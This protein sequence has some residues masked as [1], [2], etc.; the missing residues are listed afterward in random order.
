MF[1]YARS[2]LSH[3]R[4]IPL[5]LFV[6]VLLTSCAGDSSFV[7]P[8][9]EGVEILQQ[10]TSE[11]TAPNQE[12]EINSSKPPPEDIKFGKISVNQG[13]S[14]SSVSSILQDNAGLL[15]FG[16]D[17]GL[18]KYDGY[19]FTVYKHDPEN[20]NTVSSNVIQTIYEDSKG[21]LWIGTINGLDQYDRAKDIWHHFPLDQVQVI[22]ED[23]KGVLWV[24]SLAGLFRFEEGENPG[25]V[26][27]LS[28]STFALCEDSAGE[29]WVATNSGLLKLGRDREIS[30]LYQHQPQED[31][32]LA[33]NAVRDIV[34]DSD[35]KL[36]IG[37][38]G[39][40]DKFDSAGEKFTHFMHDEID[41]F[42][43]SSDVIRKIFQDISGVLWVGTDSGLN[44]FDADIQGF[45]RYNFNAD[46]P[47]SLSSDQVRTI[48][49]D[50]GGII[51]IGTDAAGLNT[52]DTTQKNFIHQK[53]EGTNRDRLSNNLVFSLFEDYSE[54]LWI[55]TGGGGINRYDRSLDVYTHYH[56]DAKNP[57]SLS[58]DYVTSILVDMEGALWAGTKNGGLN[59]LD[60]YSGRFTHY[61]H[62]PEDPTSIAHDSVWVLMKDSLGV[63]W[64]GTQGGGLDSFDRLR[65]TFIH[66]EE[67][68]SNFVNTIYEDRD[69][70][71][72]VGTTAG[73]LNLYN[74]QDGEFTQYLHDPF[75]PDSISS[76]YVLSIYQDQEGILWIG[77]AGGGLNKFDPV[78]GM[79]QHF[80]EQDGLPNDVVYGILEDENGMLWLSTNGGLSKFD[81]K[82]G[83]FRNFDVR[84]GLQSNEF[85]QNAYFKNS[86]GEMFFGGVNGY[87]SFFPEEIYDDG[88]ISPVVLT[89]LTQSGGDVFSEKSPELIKEATFRW[90]NNFFEFEFASLSYSQ[91]EKNQHAYMLEGFR[92]EEWNYIGTK[93]FGRYT[94]LP[95]G[96]YVLRIKGSNK[97]GVWNQIGNS[98]YISVI[99]PIWMTWWFQVTAVLLIV[100]GVFA[101]YWLRIRN[102]QLRTV[103]LEDQVFNRTKE[104]ATLNSIATVVSSSLDLKKILN[105]ALVETLEL[106]QIEAG[107]VYLLRD[108]DEVLSIV[109]YQGLSESFISEIDNLNVGEGFSGRVVQS[110]EVLVIPDISHDSRLTRSI[111]KDSGYHTLI[112]IPLMSR[113]KSLGTLFLLTRDQRS[114]GNKD[115]DLLTAI[116]TQIGGAIENAKYFED[117]HRRSEQFRV[118]AE[119]GRR[120]STILDVN[121]VLEEVVRLIHDTFGYYHVA[122]GIIEG[123]DVVYRVGSGELWDNRNFQ[124]K[125]ARLRVGEEGISGWVASTGKSVVVPDVSKE[126]RYVWMRGSQTRSEVTVPIIVKGKVIG[127][128]DTQSNRNND[129]DETDLAVLES[130]A[131]QTGSAIENARL[132]EQAQQAAVLEERARLARELHDAV[133][134]T[135]F[136]ASLL[137]E[138]LPTSWERDQEEGE[139][140]LD[141]LKSLNR[142]ALAEMR[143]LLIELRPSALIEANFG[144]LLQQLAEAASGREGLPIEVEVNCACSLPSDVHIALYRIVQEALNNVVKHARASH[145]YV[146]LSCSH[147]SA[148]KF[149]EEKPREI[150]LQIFDD[151]QGF[152][153][154]QPHHDKLGLGIMRE[155]AEDIGAKFDIESKPG[156]GTRITVQWQQSGQNKK[157]GDLPNGTAT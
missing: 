111:V 73:G 133:T 80:R 58:D 83:L 117:E 63:L 138:A 41:K 146:S 100:G 106:M 31:N 11:S 94:N 24:G 20:A 135:L 96:E 115:I 87:N 134:Q 148:T 122:I 150:T 76:D 30:A 156:A 14:Q 104:L 137:A 26:R 40:L 28:E 114:Y 4:L 25:L 102:V 47:E 42:S 17:D 43:I 75:D 18:N 113:G 105:D 16:T 152:A 34:L 78:A 141:E 15:W 130:L 77:T 107:G 65:E 112:V 97:D 29:L 39:G 3:L 153:D 55:G 46:D 144:D 142:G 32:S 66:Y 145:A 132:Y 74:R 89:S 125:P 36:W 45:L 127:V 44:R 124:F 13:L 72:W 126:P 7:T 116:G 86:R 64:L 62:N 56:H 68:S 140:L 129:F 51:W 88:Y 52:I 12:Q 123:D 50:R 143:T 21:Q 2:L 151:G 57:D 147:C 82:T 60:P 121:E 84:D 157:D 101:G 53:Y 99:P 69:R 136:S 61:R 59:V 5:P 81:P 49:Q 98:I 120:V 71:I 23:N 6:F 70:R 35:G 110:G 27:Q 118:L 131:H 119:V 38:L 33:N 85:N 95:G 155:R 139:K 154:D 9:A 93:R 10:V 103:E 90:P 19:E 149:G 108:S 79:F 128:L 91:P 92:D 22:M 48:S 67:L 54:I 109:A 1:Q 37:T 8:V